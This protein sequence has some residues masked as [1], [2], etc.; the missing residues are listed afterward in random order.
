M[1]S[2]T[3]TG[4]GGAQRGGN[5]DDEGGGP[6]ENQVSLMT[7]ARGRAPE[8]VQH[9]LAKAYANIDDPNTSWKPKRVI[10]LKITLEVTDD[11]RDQVDA[12]VTCES[13]LA[14]P[15]PASSRIYLSRRR[16]QV[17]ATE[18]NPRQ[19]GFDFTQRKQ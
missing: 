1:S 12:T 8:L 14:A 17:V 16:D 3:E 7:I 6:T 2:E 11:T 18:L 9:E 10:T 19:S 4:A 15:S 5:G 13:K